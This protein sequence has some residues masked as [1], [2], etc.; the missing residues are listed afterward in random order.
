MPAGTGAGTGAGAAS[1]RVRAPPAWELGGSGLGMVCA[2]SAVPAT[3]DIAVADNE[4]SNHVGRRFKFATW[5]SMKY[6]VSCDGDVAS[7]VSTGAGHGG[8]AGSS[9]HS[10]AVP[11]TG[12]VLWPSAGQSAPATPGQ[13]PYPSPMQ[14]GACMAPRA[15]A[16]ADPGLYPGASR[17]RRQRRHSLVAL[18]SSLVNVLLPGR[19][20]GTSRSMRRASACGMGPGGSEPTDGSHMAA[21]AGT[22]WSYR[23]Q[24]MPYEM[25]V[26]QPHALLNTGASQVAYTNN[27]RTSGEIEVTEPLSL[28][29]S[30]RGE[31]RRAVTLQTMH[32]HNPYGSM[33]SPLSG[34]PRAS[35]TLRACASGWLGPRGAGPHAQGAGSGEMQS[36][37]ANGH[38]SQHQYSNTCAYVDANGHVAAANL[39]HGSAGQVPQLSHMSK[40][41]STNAELTHASSAGQQGGSSSTVGGDER[42]TPR[43]K[44]RSAAYRLLGRLVPSKSKERM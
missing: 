39:T 2:A 33:G 25:P 41:H 5:S 17:A 3:L 44:H 21:T 12:G 20:A 26:M 14:D 19:S 10:G 16:G 30:P 40:K 31:F 28:L 6:Q 42:G 24:S 11:T 37:L 34:S 13:R 18:T 32:P 35:G 22:A 9:H 1:M 38:A 43:G 27:T 8:G 7:P 29:L 4:G 23:Q 36:G 15:S